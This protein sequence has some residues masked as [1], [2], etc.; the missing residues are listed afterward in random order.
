MVFE[1]LKE[2]RSQIT[3]DEFNETLKVATENIKLNRVGFNKVTKGEMFI[4]I[5]M[6]SLIVVQ[7]KGR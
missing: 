6:N 5:C 1:F 3:E 4:G 2:L 7:S